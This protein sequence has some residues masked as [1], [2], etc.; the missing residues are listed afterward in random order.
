MFI[1]TTTRSIIFLYTIVMHQLHL[2]CIFIKTEN[3]ALNEI[4]RIICSYIEKREEI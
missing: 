1:Y 2:A 3:I 4:G